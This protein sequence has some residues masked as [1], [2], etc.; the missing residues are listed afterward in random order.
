MKMGKGLCLRQ[1]SAETADLTRG[2]LRGPGALQQR[3]FVIVSFH[4]TIRGRETNYQPA[5]H[6]G[7]AYQASLYDRVE[8]V[9]RLVA[10]PGTPALLRLARRAVNDIFSDRDPRESWHLASEKRANNAHRDMA[11][12]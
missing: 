8:Q 1:S 9:N 6:R 7:I 5:R 11:A 10:C 12:W 3:D 4:A 2:V